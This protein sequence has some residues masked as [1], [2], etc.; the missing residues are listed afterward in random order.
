MTYE[1]ASNG[2]I[3]KRFNVKYSDKEIFL[4]LVNNTI[5][6]KNT[7]VFNAEKSEDYKKNEQLIDLIIQEFQIREIKL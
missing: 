1:I 2:D 7:N 5:D 3:I 6:M 4:V